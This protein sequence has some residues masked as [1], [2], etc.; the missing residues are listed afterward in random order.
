MLPGDWHVYNDEKSGQLYYHNSLLNSCTWDHPLSSYFDFLL[1]VL[2]RES[3]VDTGFECG[4]GG[5]CMQGAMGV[6]ETLAETSLSPESSFRSGG[7]DKRGV[8]AG[9][10]SQNSAPYD[11]YCIN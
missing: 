1:R 4:G 8:L 10:N 11:I 7:V 5:G 3:P 6:L 9:T 2:H